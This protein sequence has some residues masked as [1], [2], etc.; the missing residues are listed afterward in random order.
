MP[1]SL[2]SPGFTSSPVR[3]KLRLL[4]LLSHIFEQTLHLGKG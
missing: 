4:Q 3:K 2:R 1:K